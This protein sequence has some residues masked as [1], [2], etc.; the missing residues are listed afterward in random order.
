MFL[1]A[2]V[3][4][5]TGRTLWTLMGAAAVVLLIACAN[6]AN[7]FLV[8]AEGRQR[9]LAVR[10]ALGAGRAA[11][12]T[13]LLT[14]SAV[15]SLIGGALGLALA[16]GGVELLV[17]YG[18]QDLPRLNEVRIDA[19][20]IAFTFGVSLLGG[21]AFGSVPLLRRAPLAPALNE[22]GRGST[23]SPGRMRVRHV[24][25][26]AQVALSLVLL[27]ASGLMAKSFGRL[28]EVD[29]GFSQ[30]SVLA[31]G[32]SAPYARYP[33]RD[34]AAALHDRLL[35]RVRALPGVVS[36]T[37]TTCPPLAGLCWSD[38]VTVQGRPRTQEAIPPIVGRR[39][40]ADDFFETLR[41]APIA[42][43]AFETADHRQPTR[44]A[45]IDERLAQLY[46]P[47]EDPIGRRLSPAFIGESAS[48]WYEV[49]GVVPHVVVFGLA[50][51]DR[52]AQLYLPLVTHSTDGTPEPH[53]VDVLVR[54]TTDPLDLVPAVRHVLAELDPD[55]PLG[56]ITT[57]EDILDEDRAPMAFTMVLILIAGVA[58]S[59]LALVGIYGVIAFAV[60]QRAGEI[61]V[62]MA[63][64]ARPGELARMILRQGALVAS[65]GL[66]VGLGAALAA[67]R[68]LEAAL[69][70]VSAADPVIYATVAVGL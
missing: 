32:V 9:E 36:A 61:G 60:S 53:G 10:S 19:A 45:V 56:R 70:D 42:G 48:D 33:T 23:A 38:P 68:F 18:P 35:Q 46:F 7:L 29:P 57:L 34:E 28:L 44:V 39:R 1:K 67:S 51:P 15:L 59:A 8:R 25:M 41:I 66:V 58:A 50:S 26:G 37:A 4:G 31:L 3:V 16:Y 13:L 5:A 47:G 30:E 20:V 2:A 52:P 40:V 49:V 69:F 24:L 22:S 14:E 11:V 65:V 43:R 54:T 27:I 62:R 21:F 6:V 64:G 17:A 55:I 63:M 12:P